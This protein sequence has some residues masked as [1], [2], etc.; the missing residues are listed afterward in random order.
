M[1]TKGK[2][3]KRMVLVEQGMS[4]KK[5]EFASGEKRGALDVGVWRD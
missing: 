4:I 3:K 1:M 2:E 5:R